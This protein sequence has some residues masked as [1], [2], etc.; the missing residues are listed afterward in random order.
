MVPPMVPANKILTVAYGTFSCTLEGFDD[1]V[2]TMT[3]VV[4]YFRDVS[5]EGNLFEAKH[6]TPDVAK[7]REI[8]EARTNETVEAGTEDGGIVLRSTGVV[9]AGAVAS[10][11]LEDSIE[12]EEETLSGGIAND[13]VA[14]EEDPAEDSGD[15]APVG[16]EAG[17]ASE[18][19]V[20][21]TSEEE[22]TSE[23]MIT[24]EPIAEDEEPV[25]EEAAIGSGDVEIEGA[26][27]DD[28][29]LE[30]EA[31]F[32]GVGEPENFEFED[33]GN[34][35][36]T[37]DIDGSFADR[38]ARIRG[39]YESDEDSEFYAADDEADDLDT[40]AEDTLAAAYSED[41]LTD[42][43]DNDEAVDTEVEDD[44]SAEPDASEDTPVDTHGEDTIAAVA[45]LLADQ[46]EADTA[47]ADADEISEDVAELEAEAEDK[48]D[49]DAPEAEAVESEET[50]VIA[51]DE[52]DNAAADAD[53]ASE[54]ETDGQEANAEEEDADD[55]KPARGLRRI[56]IRKLRRTAKAEA[57]QTADAETP[58]PEEK[59][60][61]ID[62]AEAEEDDTLLA[63]LAAIEAELSRDA[64]GSDAPADESADDT[65]EL[66]AELAAIRAA[67]EEA[68]KLE[69]DEDSDDDAVDV[70]EAEAAEAEDET[71]AARGTPSD[72]DMERLFAAT[73]SRL[74]GED[75]SRRHANISHLKA[76]VAARRADDT[77]DVAES[78]ET[79]AYREDLANTVRP[80]AA[81]ASEETDDA[82]DEVSEAPAPLVLVSEQRVEDMDDD[83]DAPAEATETAEETPDVEEDAPVAEEDE[84][85]EPDAA[86]GDDFERFAQDVGAVDLP[87]ILEAAAAYSTKIMGEESFSRP[88]LLHLA[89]EACEDLSR[90]DGL[91]GFGQLLRE[92]RLRKVGRGTFSLGTD[93]RFA[94]EAE[95]RAG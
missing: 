53:S 94:A 16:E 87:D 56:R 4:E 17:A 5:S 34:P 22:S 55:G 24:K 21:A 11:M 42:A 79:G 72:P 70:A 13:T 71:S 63:E 19:A 65:D 68:A 85:P 44:I 81:A 40:L 47:I 32:D 84:R 14:V 18:D 35:D 86:S 66:M 57:D 23:E 89:S 74:S 90:E 75:T 58:Q 41:A 92:G 7:V 61:E 1:P 48:A 43:D 91:R 20:E 93:S 6:L 60:D 52:A 33:E 38:L 29:Q 51:E 50:Q 49:D 80:R 59:S 25:T 31:V 83:A 37:A 67:D 15:A 8:V 69:E 78:D 64:T 27:D 3:D 12:G 2:S 77:M 9:A 54:D 39:G 36:S 26:S 45:E 73:D 76:A 88:H 28:V 46:D 82:S 62:V 30:A 95:R 10:T